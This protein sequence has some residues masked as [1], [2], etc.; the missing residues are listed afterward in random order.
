MKLYCTGNNRMYAPNVSRALS[1]SPSNFIK[2]IS[3]SLA[4]RVPLPIRKTLKPI[5]KM[6]FRA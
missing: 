5:Y 4:P 2:G 1:K 6:I 3:V